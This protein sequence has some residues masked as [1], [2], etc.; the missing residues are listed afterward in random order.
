MDEDAHQWLVSRGFDLDEE[1][2]I[3]VRRNGVEQLE[4]IV[5]EWE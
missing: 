2:F 5:S 1:K 3:L 4:A